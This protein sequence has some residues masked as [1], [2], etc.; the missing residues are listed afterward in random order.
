MDS[1]KKTEARAK[2]A[3]KATG[4]NWPAIVAC[5]C[6]SAVMCVMANNLG[7]GSEMRTI[8]MGAV[9]S[10]FAVFLGYVFTGRKE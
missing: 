4:T 2:R 6:F 1:P 9:T 3:L 5:V 10:F 7:D 8:V